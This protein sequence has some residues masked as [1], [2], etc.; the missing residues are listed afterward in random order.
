MGQDLK[1]QMDLNQKL[2]QF[3]FKS[4]LLIMLWAGSQVESRVPAE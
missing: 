3:Q 2:D 4:G 1:L